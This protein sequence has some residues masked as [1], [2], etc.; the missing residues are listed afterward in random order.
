MPKSSRDF[1]RNS[2]HGDLKSLKKLIKFFRFKNL[3]LINDDILNLKNHLS[4][5]KKLSFVYI[6]CDLYFTTTKNFRTT[7]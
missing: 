6:D 5:F 4:K 7:E 3:K 2:F 1:N